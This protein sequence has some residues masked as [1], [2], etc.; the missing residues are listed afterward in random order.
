MAFFKS[1]LS[2]IALFPG[3]QDA[4]R[5][6]WKA[7]KRSAHRRANHRELICL[8][9]KPDFVLNDMGITRGDVHEALAFKGD[10]SLHLRA[11]AARRRFHQRGS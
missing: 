7:I 10:P 9:T 1:T 4:A 8:L 6:V 5:L 3:P 2:T 11:L